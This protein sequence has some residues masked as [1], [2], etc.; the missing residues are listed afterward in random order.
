M[1]IR[2]DLRSQYPENWRRIS[3]RVRF[4]RERGVCQGCGRAHGTYVRVL[5]DGRHFSDSKRCW[6][7]ARGNEV[8]HPMLHELLRA[9]TT[10][11]WLSCCHLDN[12]PSNNADSNLAALCQR[13]HL[14]QDR[15]YH[16]A[17]RKITHLRRRAMGD[18]FLG[19]YVSGITCTGK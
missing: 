5:E 7:S 15:V 11:V 3:H 19:S 1:P 13:C 6:V 18:L 8:G 12:N 14:N 9:R 16:I 17:Q 10:R 4:E 2:K